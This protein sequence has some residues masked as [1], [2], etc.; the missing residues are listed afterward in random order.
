MKIEKVDTTLN[1]KTI[2]IKLTTSNDKGLI[3]ESVNAVF[4]KLDLF[5]V[6]IK[7]AL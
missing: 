4:R 5:R 7:L 3:I 1:A 2:K 6:I